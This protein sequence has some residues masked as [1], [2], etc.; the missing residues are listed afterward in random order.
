MEKTAFRKIDN[1]KESNLLFFNFIKSN[2]NLEYFLLSW[3]DRKKIKLK[4][5]NNVS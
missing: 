2:Y 4:N 1:Y 5:Y 3:K